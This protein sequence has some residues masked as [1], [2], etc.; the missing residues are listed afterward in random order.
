MN[1][2]RK[3]SELALSWQGKFFRHN[4]SSI[5]TTYENV[6]FNSK[7]W[8]KALYGNNGLYI[9]ELGCNIFLKNGR[10]YAHC[11]KPLFLIVSRFRLLSHLSKVIVSLREF[12]ASKIP[13]AS[14]ADS[15]ISLDKLLD[16]HLL[17]EL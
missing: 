4:F 10:E 12:V 11:Q 6:Y 14:R 17:F 1:G 8:F 3:D 15:Q 9:N 16:L 5:Y 7:I 2:E 13:R